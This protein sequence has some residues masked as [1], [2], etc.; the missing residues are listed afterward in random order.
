MKIGVLGAGQLGRM[1]AIS[2][3]PLNHQFGFS[4]NSTDE[5]SALLGHM[6]A[7][8]DNKDNIESLVAFADVITYESENTDVAIVKEISNNIPVYPGEKSLFTT[9]HRGREKALFDQ[10]NIPCAP[11]QMVDSEADLKTAVEQIGLPA[12]LKTATEGY[13]GK[14][15]FLMRDE[16]QITEAWQSMNGVESILEGFVNFKRELSL[17]AVRG[18]DNDHKY[19]PLVENTHHDG[20]L[21]LTIAPAQAIEPDVQ[22]TAEHYMQTL[23]DE[24]DHVGVLTI[25][26]FETEDGLVVNEMAP[27]VHNSGHWSIEGA[28]TSQFENHVRAITGMPLG[29]TTPIH[30]FSA[31]VNIIGKNGPTEIALNMPNA[32]LHLYDKTER[33]DRKLGHINITASTQAELTNSIEKL[34]DFLP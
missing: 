15:Q 8:E 29:D 1:L 30:T 5:P 6:F 2:G 14:G 21:R 24:M 32:H 7:L 9:Q 11:Y 27:R 13:D 17:I 28:N 18:I 33:A 23:L 22:K 26:L 12:I 10:L 3:Y 31:M 34:K 16:S 4:G 19:Y 25:E 20:I